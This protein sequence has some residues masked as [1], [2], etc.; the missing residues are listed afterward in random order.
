MEIYKK[1]RPK[2]LKEVVGQTAVIKSIAT[3][4]SSYN[5]PHTMLFSGPSGVGKTTLARIL[6]SELRCSEADLIELNCADF[7]GIDMVRD[8]RT[9]LYQ[10]PLKGPCK[11]WLIDECHELTKPAQQAFLKILE[12]TPEHI[13]FFL[14]TTDPQKLLNTIKT[15]ST[16]IVLKEL[17]DAELG[18]LLLR[19]IK[20]E[21]V[22]ITN[23]VIKKIIK[24]S[25]GSARK[26]LVF[27]HQVLNLKNESDMI[28][29]IIT[30][31]VE[32]VTKTIAQALMDTRTNWKI[33]SSILKEC[34]LNEI[35]KVRRGVL[36]YASSCLLSPNNRIHSRSY[37]I[38]DSF[39]DHFFDSGK[40]GLIKSCYEIICGGQ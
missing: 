25:E 40:A 19:I 6:G 26:A 27:L 11:I 4:L 31:T 1:H 37:L 9:R 20:K 22:N 10:A 8:I 12:D 2:S 28:E 13:Y 38:I 21:K 32:S 23:K 15:R 5:L 17:S 30:S 3:M 16:E 34:E 33:M 39:Q 14:C 35:E 36:G 29:S 18:K 24:N 7:K